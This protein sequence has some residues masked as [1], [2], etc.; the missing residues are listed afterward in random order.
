[1]EED[2]SPDDNIVI[3]DLRQPNEYQALKENGFKIIRVNASDEVRL[4]RMKAL[5]DNVKPEDLN[6]ET[7]SHVDSYDVD[8]E[9]DSN[10]SIDELIQQ[11]EQYVSQFKTG[12]ETFWEQLK[13][14]LQLKKKGSKTL[15]R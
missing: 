13:S 10:G 1:L 14:T 4:E 9:L 2:T 8:F 15:I 3:T 11:A 6:H 5:G 12:R 7:E